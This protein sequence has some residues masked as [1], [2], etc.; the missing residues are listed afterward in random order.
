MH[1]AFIGSVNTSD[2]VMRSVKRSEAEFMAMGRPSLYTP[3]LA[4]SIC[5]RIAQGEML[6]DIC[7][8]QA[9]PSVSTVLSWRSM[10]HFS[11]LYI[12]AKEVRLEVMAEDL[13]SVADDLTDDPKSRSVRVDVRK[14]L[15]A[16]L[17][18]KVY[19]DKLQTEHSGAV[20]ISITPDDAKL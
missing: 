10:P 18:S 17:A 1:T 5:D 4:D 14:W 20:N 19:G 8:E 12:R 13:V 16:R 6:T 9:M 7:K 2:C 15:L 3:Q 11:Q